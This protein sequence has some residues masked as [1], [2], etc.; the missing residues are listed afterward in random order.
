MR[1]HQQTSSQNICTTTYNNATKFTGKRRQL[2]STFSASHTPHGDGNST[3][4]GRRGLQKCNDGWWVSNLPKWSVFIL[5]QVY[6]CVRVWISGLCSFCHNGVWITE[7][8]Q[9][10]RECVLRCCRKSNHPEVVQWSEADTYNFEGER[11]TGRSPCHVKAKTFTFHFICSTTCAP[12]YLL[13]LTISFCR[14]LLLSICLGFHTLMYILSL[15]F[16]QDDCL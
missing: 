4:G 12:C 6:M 10:V 3:H 1:R 2:F 9:V 8:N 14:H 7:S 15:L 11:G 13:F 16:F 5:T